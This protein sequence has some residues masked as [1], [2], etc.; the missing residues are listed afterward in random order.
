MKYLEILANKIVLKLKLSKG[1][2]NNLVSEDRLKEMY[3]ENDYINEDF[4]VCNKRK[5]DILKLLKDSP[6]LTDEPDITFEDFKNE[7]EYMLL[8]IDMINR[9][10]KRN[11]R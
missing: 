4:E 6:T 11:E 10:K 2:Y 9:D 7:F 8:K 1:K 3:N 5:E